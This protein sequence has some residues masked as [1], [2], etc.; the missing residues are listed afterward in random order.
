VA[1]DAPIATGAP[2][3]L[4]WRQQQVNPF[5]IKRKSDGTPIPTSRIVGGKTMVRDPKT[6][7]GVTVHQTACVFG[8]AADPNKKHKRAM[9]IPAQAVAFRDG[10][11]VITAPLLWYLY[12]GNSLNAPT[13]GLE[14]EGMYP[15]L[16]DDPTTV[17]RE[18]EKTTWGGKATPLDDL[19]IAT[20]RAALRFLVEEGRK[21]GMPLEFVYAHRQSN[22][23]KPSDPG[24]G[25]WEHVVLDYAVKVL[26][27][28]T[29]PQRA[30]GDGRPIPK[31]WEPGAKAAY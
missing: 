8:P 23:N 28:K 21:E 15:G 12:H 14:I 26:G 31:Q 24:Q 29:Q 17:A 3:C 5:P 6:V 9:G 7:C 20:A 25:I 30:F 19:T 4:D 10:V 16:L 11:Y 1:T 18:D 2:L 22:D 13:L 27:L